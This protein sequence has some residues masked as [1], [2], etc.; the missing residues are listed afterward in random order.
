MDF[1]VLG[2]ATRTVNGNLPKVLHHYELSQARVLQQKSTN[3]AT[4]RY[5]KADA[6]PITDFGSVSS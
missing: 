3:N 6:P 1:A 2:S 4:S 5:A